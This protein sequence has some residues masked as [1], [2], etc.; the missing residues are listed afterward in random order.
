MGVGSEL[1]RVCGGMF[2][3]EMWDG[4]GGMCMIRGGNEWCLRGA[5]WGGYGMCMGVWRVRGWDL[6]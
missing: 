6:L 1:C 2:S 5:R 4:R 3:A